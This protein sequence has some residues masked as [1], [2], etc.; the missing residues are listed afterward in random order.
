MKAG[1]EKRIVSGALL[2]ALVFF[3][4][5]SYL[6]RPL[7]FDEALT[8]QNFAF[9]D[10]VRSI[11]RNYVIPNNQLLYTVFLH[12]WVKLYAGFTAFDDW[13]RLLTLFFAAGTLLYT[14]RR[15]RTACGTGVLAVVLLTFCCSPPF[16]LHATALRGYMA[17]AFFTVLALGAALDFTV[18]GKKG[19]WI[20]YFLFSFCSAGVVPS[21]L[22]ALGGVV[23][24]A[25]PGCG[26]HFL[27]RRRFWL[28]ALTPLCATLL[29]YLPVFPLLRQVI[30]VGSNESWKDLPGVLQAVYL[31]Q[32]F[33]YAMLLLPGSAA[34]LVF[35]RKRFNYLRTC[36]AGIWL[37]PLVPILLF[38]APPF[39]RVFFPLFPLFALLVS[40]GVRDFTAIYCRSKRRFNYAVWIGGLLV[41]ALSWC[42]IQQHESVKL[43]FSRRCG[44]AGRDDF[45]LPYYLRPSHMPDATARTLVCHEKLK[46][47]KAFYL[48]FDA[49]PW[50]LMFYLLLNGVENSGEKFLFDGPRGR[51]AGLPEGTAVILNAKESAE[52][53]QKRFPGHWIREFANANHQVWSYTP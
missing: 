19:A 16:L 23:L 3:A 42:S 10:S 32:L 33:I 47:A 37:L 30:Q 34:L 2:C 22:L 36:R 24:Y 28:L 39:P 18:T 6:S 21:D 11:F 50:P 43:H 14:F 1:T 35:R 12:Y 31:P 29:F 25:L 7:W 49:D 41:L 26:E 8:L 15:F 13:L 27:R 20:R 45:Y 5:G 44:G 52:T 46:N 48:T 4:A 38:P 53:L 9:L 51:V 17:G 40:S